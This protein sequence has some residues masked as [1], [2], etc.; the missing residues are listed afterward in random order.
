MFRFFL[1]CLWLFDP[2]K[3]S[4]YHGFCSEIFQSSYVL[5]DSFG[6]VCDMLA[7]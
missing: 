6:Y 5:G 2:A 1:C 7:V 4:D 3:I